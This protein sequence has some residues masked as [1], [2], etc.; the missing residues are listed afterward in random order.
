MIRALDDH[1]FW[2]ASFSKAHWALTLLPSF[3]SDNHT[4]FVPHNRN[5]LAHGNDMT[6]LPRLSYFWFPILVNTYSFSYF[7]WAI[8]KPASP[9]NKNWKKMLFEIILNTKHKRLEKTCTAMDNNIAFLKDY[10]YK[11]KIS[12]KKII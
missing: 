10:S 9:Y 11:T 2:L 3:I 6:H 12:Q 7:S 8:A 5:L 1:P 4:H